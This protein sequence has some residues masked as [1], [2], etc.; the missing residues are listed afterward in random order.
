MPAPSVDEVLQ[1]GDTD[2][3]TVLR[4]YCDWL[5]G[6]RLPN[7]FIGDAVCGGG[8]RVCGNVRS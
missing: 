6:R 7:G 2:A 8:H 3:Q 1:E 4:E 5:C